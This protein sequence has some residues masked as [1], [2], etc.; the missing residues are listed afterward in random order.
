YTSKHQKSQL[1]S[2]YIS[3]W[4]THPQCICDPRTNPIGCGLE[5]IIRQMRVA[6]G[7]RHV[8]V[9]E[10]LADQRQAFATGETRTG[11]GMAQVMY[12]Y[13]VQTGFAPNADPSPVQVRGRLIGPTAVRKQIFA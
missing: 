11:E 7:R 5:R 6:T 4:H 2:Y 12:P 1:I 10:K 3:A 8:S 9:P 13:V